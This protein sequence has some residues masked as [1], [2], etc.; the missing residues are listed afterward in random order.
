M[1]TVTIQSFLQAPAAGVSVETLRHPAR[2]GHISF[3]NSLPVLVP[4]L[5]R[6]VD[7]PAEIV[8]DAP[9][10]LNR[11]Y[12]SGDLDLGAMSS[13]HYLKSGNLFLVPSMS[14]SAEGPVGSVLLFSKQPLEQLRGA[15][16]AVTATSASSVNMLKALLLDQL[17][18]NANFVVEQNPSLDSVSTDAVLVIGDHALAV[19][20][21]W[22]SL[23]YRVDL[24]EWWHKCY[25]LP[26]VFGL[27]A[28]RAEWVR[29]NFGLFQEICSALVEAKRI[30]LSTAFAD[31]IAEAKS[32]SG[33]TE[34]RLKKYFLE[35]LSFDFTERHMQ[36]LAKYATLCQKYNLI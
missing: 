29:T 7:M 35:E 31:V 6:L 26:F 8:I 22:S 32:K 11:Q 23:Y 3:I 19:D 5:R 10:S 15:T 24:A 18:L 13:Y 20:E 9:T 25:G 2:L 21:Q 1:D 16:I 28:A 33:L 30:G 34:E 14:I 27:W 12:A 36:G 17:S 4:V